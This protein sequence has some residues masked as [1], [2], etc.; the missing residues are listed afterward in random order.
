MGIRATT[1]FLLH[2]IR[3]KTMPLK[4]EDL[5]LCIINRSK[6]EI[7]TR[8]E[9]NF[10]FESAHKLAMNLNVDFQKSINLNLDR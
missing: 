6:N 8:V 10:E 7:P 2:W 5:F 1:N 3:S 9:S 4:N